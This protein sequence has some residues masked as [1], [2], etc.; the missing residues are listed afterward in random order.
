[1]N[2]ELE[3]L[4]L[5][6]GS[7]G[8]VEL[9][10][11][12]ADHLLEQGDPRGEVIALSLRGSLEPS[13]L[14]RLERLSA[15]HAQAWLGPLEA[16]GD[17]HGCVFQGGFLET[18]ALKAPLAARAL[19]DC[20]GDPRLCTVRTIVAG[21]PGHSAP[22]AGFLEH[23]ILKGLRRLVLDGAGW[24]ALRTLTAPFTLREV[25]LALHAPPSDLDALVAV[26]WLEGTDRLS[27]RTRE[28]VNGDFVGALSEHL[29]AHRLTRAFSDIQLE[30]R[31]GTLEGAAAWLRVRLGRPAL[32][33]SA[34]SVAYADVEFTL[35]PSATGLLDALS[36]DV[37]HEG[38]SDLSTRLATTAGVVALL[39]G[40]EIQ[41][42][43]VR[44]PEG[45]RLKRGEK[46]ALEAAAR[47]LRGV[48]AVKL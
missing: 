37:T 18:L 32:T 9:R 30:A 34:W 29:L 4:R 6:A 19:S 1:M 26:P 12:Y 13:T 44:R 45:H 27:L 14:A 22:L 46:D 15:A 48:G 38:P 39:G 5:L 10:Q 2:R 11:I 8:D 23:P 24:S 28:F 16:I 20:R 40:I 43:E 3:L 25:G 17:H 21:R 42:L 36:C 7:P 35:T 31:Y 47:R 33:A 41:R